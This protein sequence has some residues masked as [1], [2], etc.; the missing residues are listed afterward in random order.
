MEN[1]DN[2]NKNPIPFKP[3]SPLKIIAP[4]EEENEEKHNEKKTGK[5]FPELNANLETNHTMNTQT[6]D[7]SIHLNTKNDL[8]INNNKSYIEHP[9][10][11]F[12]GTNSNANLSFNSEYYDETYLNL[13]LEEKNLK[14]KINTDY[15]KN[16]ND[17]NHI[18]RE[19]LVDW[20]IEVHYRFYFKRKTLYQTVAIIDLFLSQKNVQKV[21][22]QLLGITSLLIACKENEVYY[23]KLEVFINITNNAYNKKELL[24]MEK[25]VL[26]T[27]NFE[28]L[29]PTSEEFYNI[30][31]KIFNF[32]K[33][34]K[35]LGEYFM[36]SSLLEYKMLKYKPSV[37]AA[38]CAYLVMKFF[39]IK[40]KELFLSK[41]IIEEN[42]P[43]KII[44]EC[45]KELCFLVQKLSNSKLRTTKTKY[46]LEEYGEVALLCD[47]K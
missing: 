21:N 38:G 8:N 26:N 28:I 39:G 46:S 17:I 34:Q 4:M 7:K 43:H 25:L 15:M 30:L 16:Q 24:E 45:V 3:I 19:I 13:L 40:G 33:T 32:N 42:S 20:L 2:M 36:D 5:I 27:L 6:K 37:I 47:N 9:L 31:S 22:L 1:R 18:M 12:L 11:K 23:P 14:S 29:S 41:I 44:K 10:F 35:L